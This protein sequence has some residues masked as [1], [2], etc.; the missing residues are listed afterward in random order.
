MNRE[1]RD[2]TRRISHSPPKTDGMN[3]GACST[4]IPRPTRGSA[5]HPV[6]L[7]S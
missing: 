7:I 1:S 6:L 4:A 3:W 2:G 5:Y